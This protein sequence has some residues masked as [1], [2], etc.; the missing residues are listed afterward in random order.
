MDKHK[1]MSLIREEIKKV[2]STYD[3]HLELHKNDERYAAPSYGEFAAAVGGL[4]KA[5]SYVGMIDKGSNR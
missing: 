3:R 1:V 2:K 4:K 5:L